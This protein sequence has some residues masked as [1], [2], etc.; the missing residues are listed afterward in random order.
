MDMSVKLPTC[1]I[2]MN[3]MLREKQ[4]REVRAEGDEI[5]H[6]LFDFNQHL[7]FATCYSLPLFTLEVKWVKAAEAQTLALFKLLT[8]IQVMHV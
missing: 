6:M 1:I 3:V 4:E 5:K 7:L 8:I 2:R